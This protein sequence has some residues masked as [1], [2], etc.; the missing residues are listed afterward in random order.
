MSYTLSTFSMSY[1]PRQILSNLQAELVKR[2]TELSSGRKADIGLALGAQ[3]RQSISLGVNYDLLQA[4]LASNQLI[5]AGVDAA[6][7]SLSSLIDNASALQKTLI[8][9]QTDGGGRSIIAEQART[10]LALFTSTLNGVSNNGYIFG[11]VKTDT[12]PLNNYFSKSPSDAKNAVDAAFSSAPPEGFGF[13]QSS[14]LVST[15]SSQQ[16]N[17][18]VDGPLANVFSDTEWGAN[19]SNAS[20]QPVKNRIAPGNTIETSTTANDPAL[21]KIAMAYVMMT[22][23]GNDRL[24]SEAFR[25]LASRAAEILTAGITELNSTRARVGVMQQNIKM[26]NESMQIQSN[27]FEVQIGRMEGV[28]QTEVAAKITALMTQIE[29]SYTLTAKISQLSLVKYL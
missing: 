10:S 7:S 28:D 17:D 25:T 9:S 8:N 22:D 27:V 21:R 3:T 16:I 20:S 24:S 23:L 15:I 11:G 19:W 4:H 1:G 6:Q 5:V 13:S 12:A 26:A 18:F 29:T 2:Q 14:P